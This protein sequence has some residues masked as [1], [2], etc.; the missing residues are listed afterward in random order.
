VK[1]AYLLGALYGDGCFSKEGKV[2]FSSTD[3]EFIDEVSKIVKELFKIE[4][5]IRIN[6]LSLKNPKWRDS[7]EL[8][9]R[10][11]YK[12]LSKFNPENID[13]IPN[14]IE[15][16]DIKTKA[17]FI[18]GYFDAEGG[19]YLTTIKRKDRLYNQITRHIKCF[20]NNT[21]MLE[22]IKDLLNQLQIKSSIFKGKKDNFYVGLW[23]YQSIKRFNELIGFIIKRKQ[24]ALVSTLD[25]YKV[26]QNRWDIKTYQT[27]MSLRNKEKIGA[28][29]IKY[30]LLSNGINIPQPTIEAWIYN[31]YKITQNK[32][33]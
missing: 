1:L 12:L 13:V 11:L 27:V 20:S 5:N 17:S 18:R 6:R 3:R 2:R 30:K 15:S 28:K 26:I 25:S 14:F 24:L 31:R 32:E 7:F 22:K 9:S 19:V 23:N 8:S 21:R 10:R 33:V 29:R 16:G 4:L